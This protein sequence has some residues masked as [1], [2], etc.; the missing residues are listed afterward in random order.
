M[1]AQDFPKAAPWGC[2]PRA[3]RGACT[4]VCVTVASRSHP[5]PRLPAA[6][7]GHGPELVNLSHTPREARALQAEALR[8]LCA[9]SVTATA[10]ARSGCPGALEPK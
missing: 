8:G 6:P 10:T 3:R 7:L 5:S 9:V 4:A 2:T 1:K